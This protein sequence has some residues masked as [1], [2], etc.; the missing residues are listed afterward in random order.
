M[1]KPRLCGHFGRQYYQ[2]A[3]YKNQQRRSCYCHV[4]CALAFVPNDDPEHKTQ[5]NHKDENKLNNHFSNLE[6]VTPSEN[7]NYGERN[8]KVSSKMAIPVLQYDLSGNLVASY[9]SMISASKA[10][11]IRTGGISNCVNGIYNQAGGY[12]WKKA[13][14][15]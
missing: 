4:L 5:V 8:K 2:V 6:W 15:D 14:V 12:K 13:D 10:T 7:I 3:L 11:G 9:P 1:L